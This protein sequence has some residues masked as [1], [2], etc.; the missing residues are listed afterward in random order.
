[1]GRPTAGAGELGRQGPGQDGVS[2]LDGQNM[3]RWHG[4]TKTTGDI[5]YT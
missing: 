1:M 2:W 5:P 3:T 4:E